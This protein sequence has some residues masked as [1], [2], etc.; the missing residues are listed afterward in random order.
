MRIVR[1]LCLNNSC[2]N[3]NRFSAKL[4]LMRCPQLLLKNLH[5]CYEIQ[6]SVTL[7]YGDVHIVSS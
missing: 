7:P 4:S 2:R 1:N 5:D 6:W 3:Y